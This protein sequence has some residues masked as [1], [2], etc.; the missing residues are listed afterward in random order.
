MNWLKIKILSHDNKS[1]SEIYFIAKQ[2]HAQ[3]AAERVRKI[4]SF[5]RN[6]SRNVKT[7][8]RWRKWNNISATSWRQESSLVCLEFLR[9]EDMNAHNLN[10]NIYEAIKFEPILAQ[11]FFPE[12]SFEH[13]CWIPKNLEE[14]LLR[15]Q[16][17]CASI[18]FY[19]FGGNPNKIFWDLFAINCI[20]WGRKNFLS[21][22]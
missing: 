18:R 22:M 14:I 4:A 7:E 20:L 1:Q 6:V 10:K 15:N 8:E 3:S 11:N 13:W 2:L 16:H 12:F 19:K 9:I 17:F 5:E 21:V